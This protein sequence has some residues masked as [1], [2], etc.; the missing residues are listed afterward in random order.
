MVPRSSLSCAHTLGDVTIVADAGM[1]SEA[2]KKAIEAAQ[3]VVHSPHAYP[4]IP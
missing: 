3:A 1:I 2:N 4:E